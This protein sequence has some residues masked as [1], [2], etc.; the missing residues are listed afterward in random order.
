M[1]TEN[2]VIDNPTRRDPELTGHCFGDQMV[3][4]YISGSGLSSLWNV[5][6][7]ASGITVVRSY[8]EIQQAAFPKRKFESHR[9]SKHPAYAVWSAAKQRGLMCGA[10]QGFTQFWKDVGSGWAYG[11]CAT[12]KVMTEPMSVDNFRWADSVGEVIANSIRCRNVATLRSETAKVGLTVQ[13]Y[14]ARRRRGFTHEQALTT[15]RMKTGRRPKVAA[16][17]EGGAS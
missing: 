7:A 9:M 5:R 3:V 14:W 8:H 1:N 2:M 12:R 17:V 15:P 10:W 11:K 16:V 6:L 13:G 4:S